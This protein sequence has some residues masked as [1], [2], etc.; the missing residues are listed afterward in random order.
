MIL[1]KLFLALVILARLTFASDSPSVL[2]PV[3]RYHPPRLSSAH[4]TPSYDITL[5]YAEPGYQY[6]PHYGA[7]VDY[8]MNAPTLVVKDDKFISTFICKLDGDSLAFATK[9]AYEQALDTWSLPMYLIVE[10]NHHGCA[11]TAEGE[12]EYRVIRLDSLQSKDPASLTLVFDTILW[13]WKYAIT[14]YHVY[15]GFSSKAAPSRDTKIDKRDSVAYTFPINLDNNYNSYLNMRERE[16]KLLDRQVTGGAVDGHAEITCIDCYSKGGLTLSFSTGSAVADVIV[17]VVID[18]IN[19][20]SL[21]FKFIAN[22]FSNLF[23]KLNEYFGNKAAYDKARDRV[24]SDINVISASCEDVIQGLAK[25][26]DGEGV[27]VDSPQGQKLLNSAERHLYTE[28]VA[29]YLHNNLYAPFGDIEKYYKDD[30][31]VLHFPHFGINDDWFKKNPW[32][33]LGLKEQ[34][35][36]LA[37]GTEIIDYT[38]KKVLAIRASKSRRSYI[39]PAVSVERRN[40]DGTTLTSHMLNEHRKLKARG[41]HF[42]RRAGRNQA[43]VAMKGEIDV[44]MDV[45]LDFQIFEAGA[46]LVVDS[47]LDVEGELTGKVRL[48]ASANWKGINARANLDGTPYPE[49]IFP[50]PV[51]TYKNHEIREAR[52]NIK[53]GIALEPQL[54]LGVHLLIANVRAEAGLGLKYGIEASAALARTSDLSAYVLYGLGDEA[55][56]KRDVIRTWPGGD[57]I[58]DHCFDLSQIWCQPGF[59]FDVDR[60]RCEEKGPSRDFTPLLTV[61]RA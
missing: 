15:G 16:I 10:N 18:V 14:Y 50:K 56:T 21:V 20:I 45:M 4:T 37:K 59:L 12:E 49:S 8:K 2:R 61:P 41:R 32:D 6:G 33:P 31:D 24:T 44:N 7:V 19:F 58:W 23:D 57:L 26:F 25:A 17:G 55:D 42:E 3:S 47:V 36:G 13:R 48:G 51:F 11:F 28:K 1:H 9:A 29:W 54:S 38:Y 22:F 35:E 52:I 46:K 43:F 60:L 34:K 39:V 53:V 30:W 27:E 5:H 40:L